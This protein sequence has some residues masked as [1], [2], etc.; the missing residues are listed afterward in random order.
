MSEFN[1][2]RKLENRYTFEGKLKLETP[3][4]VSS[5]RASADT[6]APVMRDINGTPFIPGS[7]LRGAIRSELERVIAVVG[8]AS[9]L[10]GCTLFE[11]DSCAEKFK[12]MPEKD[13]SDQ[14]AISTFVE[15]K[16]CDICRL[17]GAT[18]YASR[19]FIDDA[20]PSQKTVINC[21]VR[22]GVGIHRDN[23]AA[24]ENVKFDYE[25]IESDPES[26]PI[27]NFT[28]RVENIDSGDSDKM[29]INVILKLLKNGLF[30]GGKRSGGMGKIKLTE[31]TVTGFES[32]DK[33]WDA[34]RNG[35]AI[36]G[37][38]HWKEAV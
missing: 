19:L 34:F 6:D 36:E 10:R 23:G 11:N 28:M 13:R 38:I 35:G 16:L 33:L 7:S 15:T 30:V 24:V 25:V 5:G 37:T 21:R 9:G 14:K 4:K 18:M 22:D 3:L 12:K 31:Y 2:H 17:F 8:E 27:F 1:G 26:D 32:P 29:L 20:L